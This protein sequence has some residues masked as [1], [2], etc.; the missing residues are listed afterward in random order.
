MQLFIIGQLKKYSTS[1][2]LKMASGS[3]LVWSQ[4]AKSFE[5]KNT[6]LAMKPFMAVGS[7]KGQLENIKI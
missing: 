1:F 5:A 2:H 4:K 3:F 6:D 7:Q